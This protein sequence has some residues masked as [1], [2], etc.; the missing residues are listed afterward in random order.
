MRDNEDPKYGHGAGG[1][2][3]RST[4]ERCPPDRCAG[5]VE[6]RI[7][8]SACNCLPREEPVDLIRW[9]GHLDVTFD[10][11]VDA[12]VIQRTCDHSDRD[13]A[14]VRAAGVRPPEIAALNPCG[15]ADDQPDDNQSCTDTHRY[16]QTAALHEATDGPGRT[17]PP[18]EVS[19]LASVQNA[20]G[21]SVGVYFGEPDA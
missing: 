3:R 18:G 7:A 5:D 9:L 20:V 2:L 21:G 10:L 4:A 6:L 15:H 19:V 8:R 11:R 16:L 12:D 13:V 17:G 14:K 1:T